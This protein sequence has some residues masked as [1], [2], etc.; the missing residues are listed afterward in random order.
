MRIYLASSWKNE[1]RVLK[2]A[3]TL[4]GMGHEV[5]AFCDASTGRM[6]FNWNA[7]SKFEH[8]TLTTKTAM[9]HPIP[10]KAFA[11]DRKWLD[12]SE[13]V[14]LVLPA[15]NS[16]HLEAGYA[17]GQGKRLFILAPLGGFEE[18]KFDVMYGFADELCENFL[19]LSNHLGFA[20]ETEIA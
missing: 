17:K 16:A 12:W 15:G 11:E 14:V 18:G 20:L 2:V 9:K 7:L 1:A 6:S 3:N 10:Q 4:R 19:Q 8:E 5:D 13:C